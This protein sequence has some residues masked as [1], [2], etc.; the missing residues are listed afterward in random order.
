MRAR[1]A[2]RLIACV[3]TCMAVG[4]APA[5][6][7]DAD[8]VPLKRPVAFSSLSLLGDGVVAAEQRATSFTFTRFDASSGDESLLARVPID[9]RVVPTDGDLEIRA[10][11]S[12]SRLAATIAQSYITNGVNINPIGESL[13]SGPLSRPLATLRRCATAFHSAPLDLD[14]DLLVAAQRTTCARGPGKVLYD[15][16]ARDFAAGG[17]PVTLARDVIV[18]DGR[19][20]AVARPYAAFATGAEADNE[21]FAADA[22]DVHV[23]DLRTGAEVTRLTL[24]GLPSAEPIGSASAL[25][26]GTDGRVV[27]CNFDDRKLYWAM[28]GDRAFRKTRRSCRDVQSLPD[29][30][31]ILERGRNIDLAD[32]VTGSRRVLVSVAGPSFQFDTDGTRLA[33]TDTTC[34]TE[35]LHIAPIAALSATP[36]DRLTCIP[37][38]GPS[39]TLSGRRATISFRCPDGCNGEFQ[40][41]PIGEDLPATVQRVD[42]EPGASAKVTLELSRADARKLARARRVGVTLY[43]Y[44]D[45]RYYSVKRPVR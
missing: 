32:P 44:F 15:I 26:V 40:L 22:S 2:A 27:V 14:G 23:V 25:D 39:V 6:A 34:R 11:A 42:P 13:L 21:N 16:V 8:V 17:A 9:P 18:G 3:A 7:G 35:R 5:M 41:Y 45:E 29:G 24:P 4:A 20:I 36:A 19:D 37:I 1:V 10:R 30:Q 38:V 28:P 33:W 31:V 12:S 43:S